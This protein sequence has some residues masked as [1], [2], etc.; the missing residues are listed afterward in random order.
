MAAVMGANESAV[1]APT[2]TAG[3]AY[4]GVAFRGMEN[5]ITLT[6]VLITTAI[7]SFFALIVMT[8]LAKPGTRF[9]KVLR[10]V[11]GVYLIA[12]IV[13]GIA[14]VSRAPRPQRHTRIESDFDRCMS[15]L[16]SPYDCR[17][18]GFSG[19]Y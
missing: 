17:G 19:D 1:C 2:R 18:S 4:P 9:T 15:Q 10:I 7:I 8:S 12:G 13:G 3:L 6:G 11:W 5:E 14:A 16:D